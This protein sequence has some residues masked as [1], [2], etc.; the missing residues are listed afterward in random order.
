MLETPMRGHI[1]YRG[2][3]ARCLGDPA[4]RAH[5]LAEGRRCSFYNSTC[6]FTVSGVWCQVK[7]AKIQKYR[8]N[9]SPDAGDWA[10][11]ILQTASHQYKKVGSSSTKN[12][13]L[14]GC[15]Q[16]C[17]ISHMVFPINRVFAFVSASKA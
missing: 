10:N 12:L 7:S 5:G 11:P 14:K 6:T 13:D 4:T 15:K 3:D 16:N 2:R 8:D 17:N 1:Q 9:A